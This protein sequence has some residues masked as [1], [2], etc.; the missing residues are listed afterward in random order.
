MARSVSAQFGEGQK[1]ATASDKEQ[2]AGG[3]NSVVA[4]AR[5]SFDFL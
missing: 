1:S 3:L 5:F 2:G 4:W